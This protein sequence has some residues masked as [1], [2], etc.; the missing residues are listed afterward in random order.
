MKNLSDAQPEVRCIACWS[1][2]RYCMWLFE[3]AAAQGA[4]DDALSALFLA[5]LRALLATMADT[6]PKVGRWIRVGQRGSGI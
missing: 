1:V 5:T 4:E 3:G 6:R 2:S